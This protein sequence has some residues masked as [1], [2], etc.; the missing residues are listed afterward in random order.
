[1]TLVVPFEDIFKEETKLLAKHESWER[2]ELGQVCE[3]LNGFAFKS[4]LF[5]K[6][7]GVPVVRIRD[8]MRGRT[9]T[10]YK[11]DYPKEYVVENGDLL[12]GMDGNFGCYEWSGGEALLNQRVCKLIP[13]ENY[14]DRKFLLFGINGYLKAIQEATS[15]VTVGHLSSRDIQRIPFPFP[16]LNEQ[17]RI[18]AKLE[19]LLS[20]VD[21]A[22]AR[23]TAI[24]RILKRFRQSVLAAACSGRL[25]ADWRE[26]NTDVESA[27]NFLKRIQA[28]RRA[29]WEKVELRKIK[30]RGLL[31]KDDK[32]KER[33]KEPNEPEDNE[34]NG[35]PPLWKWERLD[36]VLAYI[37]G[38]K[39]FGC[40]ERP[41]LDNEVGVLKVSAV[42]WGE[43]D[44]S[45]SKTCNDSKLINPDIQV[46][47]GDFL[48]S[49]A[50]TIE[51]VG[52]CVIVK[53]ISSNLMLSDKTLRLHIAGILQEYV[54][55]SLRTSFGRAEIERLATG[56]QNSMRNIGQD[57]IRDILVPVPP[58][59]EQQEIVRRVE[60]LFKTADA[61][62]ARYRTAKA[63]VDKLAQS[64][65]AKAFRG[66]LVPQDP[67][68]EPA[69]VLLERIRAKNDSKDFNPTGKRKR[70]KASVAAS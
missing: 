7:Q 19:K 44:E 50:N 45:E 9:E 17:R 32:W 26:T 53:Q 20:R 66:E 4:T 11:G 16:S 59:A 52:A 25:T 58:L 34:Q 68:D 36:T 65:L 63:H 15:S 28:N 49:R 48:F 24:P 27:A 12:V 22:Q 61:L 62:E 69:S 70:R 5:N 35:L 13:S 8:L 6:S 1:M 57:R 54:L 33:Y 43:F 37:E 39:S 64:I 38:G 41:P 29:L 10:F 47:V 3:V 23:L 30:A 2:V 55:Y 40:T 51:L 56:N 42:T 14:L 67:S 46:R 21:A 18:V 31:P 60:A